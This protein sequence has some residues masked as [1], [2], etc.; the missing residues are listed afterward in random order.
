[1]RHLVNWLVGLLVTARLA[2]R[3]QVGD[4]SRCKCRQCL[5]KIAL[6]RRLGRGHRSRPLGHYWNLWALR[7][8]EYAGSAQSTKQR[9][10]KE[11]KAHQGHNRDRNARHEVVGRLAIP[12]SSV[13]L[14]AE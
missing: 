13:G 5:V 1:I 4:E 10:E 7:G 11:G 9:E 14:V 2:A 8:S 12:T 3:R 6:L